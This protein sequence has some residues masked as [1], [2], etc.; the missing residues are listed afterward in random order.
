MHTERNNH[1]NMDHHAITPSVTFH[2]LAAAYPTQSLS[3]DQ[4]RTELHRIFMHELVDIDEV[5]QLLASLCCATSDWEKYAYFDEFRYT[6]NL[7]DDGNDKFNL[8][9]LCWGEGQA[10]GIHEHNG[11][12]CF[13]KVLSGEVRETLYAWPESF[14]K[15]T[16]VRRD[17]PKCPLRL[18]KVTDFPTDG[19]S[20]I[21][22]K[23]GLHRIENPSHTK[24]AVSLHVY[25][26]PIRETINFEE[27]TGRTNQCRPTFYS[28]YG[29]RMRPR[30]P[31]TCIF[32]ESN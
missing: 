22:D 15:Q 30:L 31:E 5:K 25:C 4:L 26:P 19:V 7:I 10:T 29:R 3:L 1:T 9:L 11:A 24:R 23:I 12:H 14:D 27:A 8:I 2:K 28:K 20:Y 18:K 13:F 21:H 16:P 6:R 17:Q 32:E